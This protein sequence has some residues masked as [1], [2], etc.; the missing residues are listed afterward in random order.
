[1]K[2]KP[3]RIS[4]EK[5]LFFFAV[6]LFCL[7]NFTYAQSPSW[8]VGL[9][10]NT[11]SGANAIVPTKDGGYFVGGN[12]QSIIQE[13]WGTYVS[14]LD[15]LGK[16]QW[17]IHPGY[18]YCNSVNLT[19]DGGYLIVGNPSPGETSGGYDVYV[20]KLDS[21]GNT[22][23]SETIGGIRDDV[24]YS[25]IPTNDG[26]YAITGYT[27]SFFLK[28]TNVYVIKLNIAG[29]IQWTR[30][31]GN[32]NAIGQDIGY[33]ITQTKDGG[34]AITGSTTSFGAGGQDVYVIKLDS[35]GNLQ[36]TKTIGGRKKDWGNAIIQSMD[37]G[38]AITGVTCSFADSV[39][40]DVYIIK[41]DS[42]GNLQWTKTVG[43]I[44]T[45][46]GQSILQN[47]DGGYAITGT[48]NSYGGGATITYYIK[49]DSLGILTQTRT[50]GVQIG[51]AINYARQTKNGGFAA[52][53]TIPVYNNV[54]YVMSLDSSGN[55]CSA[56]SSGGIIDSGGTV[57]SGG[58]VTTSDSGRVEKIGPAY[59]SPYTFTETYFCSKNSGGLIVT[60]T[61]ANTYCKNYPDGSITL[62][63]SGGYRPYTYLWSPNVTTDSSATG[64]SP[65]TYSI[66][67]KDSLNDSVTMVV[68]LYYSSNINIDFYRASQT[69]NGNNNGSFTIVD[70]SGTPP[71]AYSWSNGG[72]S[73]SD[74]NLSAGTYILTI[75]DSCGNSFIDTFS[76][77]LATGL[78]D[79]IA[80]FT[81]VSCYD[82][83]DG[84]AIVGAKGSSMPFTYLWSDANHQTT[85]T[86]SGL[87]AGTYTVA[88]T[89]A[90]GGTATASI[91]IIQPPL[92]QV[93]ASTVTNV[94][95]FGG[96]TG[97]ATPNLIGPLVANFS[98]E[99]AV[100]HFK[101]PP[102]VTTITISIAGA[103]GGGGSL[104]GLGANFIGTASVIP[105]DILSVA[106]GQQGGGFY[107]GGGGA[108]WVYDSN[109]VLYN[110]IGNLGLIAVAGGGGGAGA[111]TH[112]VPGVPSWLY[113]GGAGGTNLVTNATNFGTSSY[114]AGGT[115]GNGGNVY[116]GA[117]G[118]GWLS[119]GQ[120]AWH[121]TGGMDEAHH[122]IG[123]QGMGGYGG[124]GAGWGKCTGPDCEYDGG[125]GGGYNGGGG[126]DGGCGGGSYFVN[127]LP[128]VYDSGTGNGYLRIYYTI[129]GYDSTYTYKWS[130][131]ETTYTATGLSAGIYTLTVSN[132]I[133][134]S[135]TVSVTITQPPQ[136]S[137][138]FHVTKNN[139]CASTDSINAVVTGGT[140]PYSYLWSF[141]RETA[142][143]IT[144][145]PYCFINYNSDTL[146][147]TDSNGCFSSHA[148][149]LSSPL[150]LV[151]SP[152]VKNVSCY[153]GNNGQCTITVCGGVAP[154]TY[155]FGPDTIISYNTVLTDNNLPA[156]TLNVGVSDSNGCNPGNLNVTITQPAPLS[157]AKGSSSDSSGC[158]GSAWVTV[159]GGTN[160]YTYLWTAGQTTDTISNQCLGIYCCT[161]T[162]WQGCSNLA[163]IDISVTGEVPI[164]DNGSFEVYPNPSIG[165]FSF[166]ISNN[167]YRI[168]NIEVYDVLGKKVFSSNFPLS[169]THYSINLS[170]QP[171][172]I[173]FYWVLKE[174][175]ELMGDGK[176]IIQK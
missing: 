157:L 99:P 5:F 107:N 126:G 109:V 171:N 106:V 36:W 60:P 112:R 55:N 159:S 76:I 63:V 62:A 21:M 20:N 2:V 49:L 70:V 71:F 52:V 103:Q 80:F 128:I 7:S 33:A 4:S 135:A 97:S 87:K 160:P 114:G 40:G 78:R 119:N 73:S 66:T 41:L 25:I 158:T 176:L 48:T 162:D 102:S 93:T 161:V 68:P 29:N 90:C 129:T 69:C 108:S 164:K 54:F 105:G 79:S 34:Y 23:W 111:L 22:Q 96:S 24:G 65:G 30:T 121:D 77:Y 115:G 19:H 59:T 165:I 104:G 84:T 175:G 124:G 81:N 173:Y 31:I 35:T 67:V 85:A 116:G 174:N 150:Y 113:Y 145:M 142:D 8:A 130:N 117:G 46:V 95:C 58:I 146:F 136:V 18:Y 44:G 50:Y 154:F 15:S 26:G 56:Y 143:T 147:I 166:Q 13:I 125:G 47:G 122:F 38:Y 118:S 92:W 61:V 149:Y 110:P 132:S 127:T 151:G 53:G 3:T 100:Q 134:C 139:I 37:G 16:L 101:V 11:V 57:S 156:G 120:T 137:V 28:D 17:A 169:T 14:K 91:T 74:S 83:S 82:D 168:T 45:D 144:F 94:S 27:A 148:I 86:A 51:G 32:A 138:S 133:G 64:L 75:S 163:C 140:T 6:L 167:E 170:N 153:N 88:V 141:G 155:Y 72:T 152:I 123:V 172:G 12:G 89:D 42:V 9:Q 39:N 1:M 10:C 131:G 98:F 43:G